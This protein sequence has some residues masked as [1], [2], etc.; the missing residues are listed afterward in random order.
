MQL[1]ELGSIRT[2]G[3]LDPGDLFA[4]SLDGKP[5]LGLKLHGEEDGDEY[6][7]CA[8]LSAGLDGYE[9]SPTYVVDSVPRRRALLHL[10][11]AKLVP[12][13]NLQEL[14]FSDDGASLKAGD[15]VYTEEGLHLVLQ[16]DRSH[17]FAV[18][19]ADGEIAS[20]LGAKHAIIPSW[21]VVVPGSKEPETIFRWPPE[22]KKQA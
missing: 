9:A 13:A 16:G 22:A 2:W 21:C 7:S 12:G 1:L 6:F 3:D 4:L 10:P 20:G 11:N 8:V 5:N 19:V 14:S 18:R 15:L 17:R